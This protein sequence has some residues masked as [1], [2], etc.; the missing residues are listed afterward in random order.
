MPRRIKVNIRYLIIFWFEWY[1]S[2]H[3]KL[4]S[5][6]VLRSFVMNGPNIIN[7][8]RAA[9]TNKDLSWVRNKKADI[10]S[11]GNWERR[12]ILYA[13]QVLPGDEKEHWLKLTMA[14]SPLL[15]DRW[16]SKWVLEAL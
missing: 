4:I 14:S 11:V 12:A 16:V 6:P 5:D 1:F 7:Q 13:A 2:R 15:T 8:A 3:K 10:F 9:V